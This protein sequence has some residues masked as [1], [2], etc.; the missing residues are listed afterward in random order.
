MATKYGDST[1]QTIKGTAGADF[2]YGGEG[3]DILQGQPLA[4]HQVVSVHTGY[5]GPAAVCKP[6]V[7]GGNESLMR[8]RD[9]GKT[10]VLRCK[11]AGAC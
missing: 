4:M 11:P 5:K 9:N 6:G 8:C 3:A 1:S 7:Q 2:L 10:G